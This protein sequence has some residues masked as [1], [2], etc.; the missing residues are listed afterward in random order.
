MNNKI[1]LEIL[2]NE[3]Q[4][5][6]KNLSSIENKI[7]ELVIKK[8]VQRKKKIISREKPKPPTEEE[9]AM[10]KEEFEDLFKIWLE[11]KELEVLQKLEQLSPDD[12]RRFADSNNLN[13]TSKMSKDKVL[14]LINLRFREKR[15][16][17]TN[18]NVTKPLKENF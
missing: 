11:G 3:F 10:D 4:D 6:K 8:N 5:I 12:I 16:M 18:F 13:V 9:V 7:D 15:M 2:Y 17:L 14:N 1:T